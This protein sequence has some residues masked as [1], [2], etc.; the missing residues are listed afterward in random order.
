MFQKAFIFKKNPDT[1]Y[2]G[3]NGVNVSEKL[4]TPETGYGFVTVKNRAEQELLQIPAITSGFIPTENPAAGRLI[5]VMFRADVPHSGNY[6]VEVNA[7]NEVLLHG[8]LAHPP[9]P[10]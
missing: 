5:P 2:T 9:L 10:S 3:R 6:R 1:E 4:Y 8:L 7:T